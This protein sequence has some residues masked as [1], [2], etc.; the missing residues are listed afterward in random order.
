MK[1]PSLNHAY[2][3][4]WSQVSNAWVAV[5]EAT[6]GHGKSRSGNR[7][8]KRSG[9]AL[10]ASAL[11]LS[12]T[13]TF[14]D[15]TGG[16]VVSGAGSITQTTNL[17]TINQA[18]QTLGL[19]WDTFNINVG[20]T[21]NFIQPNAAALAV[22]R[23]FDTNG[24]RI[25]GNLNANG[26]VWLINPNGVFFGAGSQVNVGSIL[27]STLNPLSN[28]GDIDQ[29]F[30]NGG[31]GS[32][33]NQGNITAANSGY[34]AMLGNKVIN[35][36]VITAQMGTVALGAGSEVSLQFNGNKLLGLTVNEST[37]NNLA[38]NNQ[39]VKADGGLV[40]MS[41]GAKDSILA[42]TV[43][44]TGV[45]EAQTVQNQD[46]KI[47]LMGGMAAGTTNVAGTLDAS[48][49][50][51]NGGFIETSAANV[52]I[53][54][55]T[56]VTT[57]A[58][59]GETGTWLIDPTDFTVN[60]GADN[61]KR[62]SIGADTLVDS[63]GTS[64]ITIQT[65]RGKGKGK[66]NINVDAAVSW[67]SANALTLKSRRGVGG[68]NINQDITFTNGGL[69]LN[70][71]GTITATG[72]I[73]GKAFNLQSGTWN[74]VGL[75]LAAFNVADFRISGGTFIR[76]LGGDGKVTTPY[77]LTDVYG[78]QGVGSAGMLGKSYTLV[79]NIDAKGTA[80]WNTGAGFKPLGNRNSK[81]TGT[82]D[83]LGH[84]VDSLVVNRPSSDFIGL[85]GY[86]NGGTIKNVGITNVSITGKNYTGGLAG[87][88]QGNISNSY[89]TGV[90]SGNY[91]VG[92]LVGR[93]DV[94]S[95]KN[96][97]ATVDVFGAN[98]NVGGLVGKAQKSQISNS[99]AAGSVTGKDSVGG[100]I[101]YKYLGRL[102]NSYA[103]GKV[104]GNT[105]T[106]GL[107]GNRTGDVSNSF[108]NTATSGVGSGSSAG[109]T[110]KTTTEMQTLS[111]FTDAGW[112]IDDKG[113]TDKTWRI[114]EGQTAPLLRNFMS[115]LDL[116]KDQTLTYNGGTQRFALPKSAD[117]MV[118]GIASGRNAD[119]Y[120]NDAYSGQ[121]GYD[122][123][124]G[125]NLIINPAT[126]HLIATTDT[127]TYDGTTSTDRKVEVE[128]LQ[129]QNENT[130]KLKLATFDERHQPEAKE[131]SIKNLTQSFESKNV[132][133]G[134]KSTLNVNEDFVID[135][136]N[137]GMNYKVTVE[138]NVGT[139]NKAKATVTANSKI[140]TYKGL[141]Q[142]VDGF[143]VSGL[144]NGESKEVLDF[145][146]TSGEKEQKFVARFGPKGEHQSR[147]GVTR[148]DAGKYV[149]VAYGHDNNYELGFVKGA[150]RIDKAEA[151]VTANSKITTYNG[152]R[153]SVDGFT[154][155][156]LVNGESKEVLDFVTT[157]GEKEQ[158]FVARFGP[159]GEH[160]SRS[161]VTRTDA[162]KYVH[163]A[164]G[165]DNNYELGFVKGALRI[166][167]ATLT[168]V[169][170]PNTMIAG[171]TPNLTGDVT[172]F[173][174]GDGL[175]SATTGG[176]LW[177][178]AGV[179]TQP[180]T[181]DITG[182][183]LAALN[184]GFVQAP[185]NA[186]ALT[187]QA[188]SPSSALR[189]T[190][191]SLLPLGTAAPAQTQVTMIDVNNPLTASDGEEG[192]GGGFINDPQ[193]KT[194]G[195]EVVFS[196]CDSD[197]DEDATP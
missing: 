122:I 162:G 172:G 133:G 163:V 179:T 150:L 93:A 123:I 91:A 43:N 46:G 67:G 147:S 165:H 128:G 151:T 96:S 129:T 77:Q 37:L 176:L 146:T 141:E 38:A 78:L 50:Q 36:G 127:K 12:P 68:I 196:S 130:D 194:N 32:V 8:L 65:S 105:K 95:I 175:A 188:G 89:A 30:G 171:T 152:R 52:R 15:Q 61:P 183:G 177:N 134:N 181:Y 86:N 178:T 70:A 158:K 131:D 29:V 6:K 64:D 148:T 137:G 39:L 22:N 74:Q 142:S 136:G 190:A 53:A 79:N 23:I 58:E 7:L 108:W 55:G 41:A 45:I 104:T 59:N 17:T 185:I 186:T 84:T 49:A 82:F 184:Y 19:T 132:L 10:V 139:I 173:V 24:S 110:G 47:I 9:A 116:S 69:N 63:L 14:A 118:L 174:G 114:Y 180:G 120:K 195:I 97:Y 157:S 193:S 109:I 153:Q 121:Q 100:L 11:L 102:S 48:A 51:G 90:V 16:A 98:N 62:S 85:F 112:D 155:S 160:Q 57:Q 42:S 83:G 72:A 170:T 25:M 76:A 92:G 166:D 119:T 138:S 164:Y 94:S 1:K 167:K 125:G 145:V 161:G 13:L 3:L 18:S 182:S 124:D 189:T 5:S 81:F 27:A 113:G 71:T 31:T 149:H 101:G 33:I 143:T 28:T 60:A 135:D 144:V 191:I 187:V 80:K 73:N 75:T 117:R 192:E 54:E 107:I 168:Y 106:G 159:K 35:E 34:V 197:C 126:L 40:F 56:K 87:R 115:L 26:Q 156:G 4:I 88:N 20:Q 99:Y 44:N 66:G 2:R 140:T 154:V 103:A 169:A 21:V 111:T